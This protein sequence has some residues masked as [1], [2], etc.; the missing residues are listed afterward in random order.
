MRPRIVRG[1]LRRSR[2]ATG[3]CGGGSLRSAFVVGFLYVTIRGLLRASS[4]VVGLFGFAVFVDGALALPQQIKNHD[5]VQMA[6]DLGPF[7]RR[8]WHG[9]QRF[10]KRI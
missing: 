9:L 7:L 5:E 10:A 4:V 3:F 2:F 8:F 6:P 1:R